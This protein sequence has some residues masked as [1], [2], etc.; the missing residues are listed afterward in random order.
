MSIPPVNEWMF[1]WLAWKK[2]LL[3]GISN[4]LAW[5]ICLRSLIYDYCH[6]WKYCIVNIDNYLT[7]HFKKWLKGIYLFI[8]TKGTSCWTIKFTVNNGWQYNYGIEKSKTQK[9]SCRF[10]HNL[11]CTMF[12]KLTEFLFILNITHMICLYK[13]YMCK[14]CS[15]SWNEMQTLPT[16]NGHCK[17]TCQM[18]KAI[19]INIL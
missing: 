12:I 19:Y 15:I 13:L 5:E 16:M 4:S 3:V 7:D 6:G 14:V 2:K 9:I 10:M 11:K 1:S 8:F 18:C 17:P